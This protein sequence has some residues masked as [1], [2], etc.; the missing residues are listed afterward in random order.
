MVE[1]VLQF[2]GI[3][4]GRGVLRTPLS[5]APVVDAAIGAIR[6][7]DDRVTIERHV[8][9]D[10]PVVLGD[11][12]MLRSAVHNLLANAAKYGG[13]DA[14]IG[15]HVDTTGAGRAREVRIAVA[16]RGRGIPAADLPHI[17]E[18]FYRGADAVGR[19]IQGSGLG[20]AL[21][22]R[23]VEAHGGRVT[24][25]SGEREATTFTIV[26][27][28]FRLKPEGLDARAGLGDLPSNDEAVAR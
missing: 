19:Q 12:D 10:V 18:P 13:A 8:A 4:S 9:T 17:F 24:V 16:D 14:W 27:P 1:R 2:A 26:L 28:V 5:I 7:A 6:A 20:L 22:R 11:A 21:V 23:I 25:A 15:V 3:E